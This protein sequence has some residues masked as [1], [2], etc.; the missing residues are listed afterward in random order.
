LGRATRIANFEAWISDDSLNR[1]CAAD[2]AT[3]KSQPIQNWLLRSV[4]LT[5]VLPGPALSGRAAARH[6]Y[7]NPTSFL[8]PGLRRDSPKRASHALVH[9]VIDDIA[10]TKHH[11]NANQKRHKKNGHDRLLLLSLFVLAE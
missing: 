7:E 6:N 11:G 8:T 1:E 2:G 3:K 9:Q 4:A 10:A 5:G